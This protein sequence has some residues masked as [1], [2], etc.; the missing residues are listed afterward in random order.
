MVHPQEAAAET[1][2]NEEN[3][4]IGQSLTQ[5]EVNE[6]IQLL[7]NQPEVDE[8]DNLKLQEDFDHLKE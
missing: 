7:K 4:S 3:N 5:Q 2:I 6:Y 8:D 1:Y